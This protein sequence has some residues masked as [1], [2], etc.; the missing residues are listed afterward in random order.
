MKTANE[1]IPTIRG[2]VRRGD[3]M[4]C[5]AAAETIIKKASDLHAAIT[6]EI[7]IRGPMTDAEL[8]DLDRFAGYAH[9][10]VSKR[11]T[12]LYQ[13]GLLV[14]VGTRRNARGS[15]M[16]VW[17]LVGRQG[18]FERPAQRSLFVEERRGAE[19]GR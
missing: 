10:S 2:M 6:E 13:A 4:T 11:R 5:R 17:D 7:R 1:I 3:P 14:S 12:E 8:R 9:S 18:N 16:L 15:K 19:N